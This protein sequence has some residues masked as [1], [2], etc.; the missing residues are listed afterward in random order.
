M[1]GEVERA[2]R[3]A[4]SRNIAIRKPKSPI[5]LTMNAFLP[6]SALAL[7][8]EP[9]ADQQVGAE[10][11]A[12]PSRRTAPGSWTPSTSTSMKTTNRFR[13]AK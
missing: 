4:K 6:A 12:L 11:D 2:E 13:Y 10:P 1:L 8:A 7:L 3:R 9:E 5:R